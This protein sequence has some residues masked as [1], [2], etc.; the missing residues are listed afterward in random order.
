MRFQPVK[1]KI[2]AEAGEG[3]VAL[4]T[5]YDRKLI[6]ASLAAKK[7][8]V[9][10]IEGINKKTKSTRRSTSRRSASNT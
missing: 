10:E 4:N 5:N 9:A 3:T 8:Y 2:V 1:K 7:K 6:A